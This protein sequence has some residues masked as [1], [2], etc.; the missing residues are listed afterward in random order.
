MKRVELKVGQPIKAQ[1]LGFPIAFGG[2]AIEAEIVNGV[3][4]GSKKPRH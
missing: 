1:G 2:R 4:I 3:L